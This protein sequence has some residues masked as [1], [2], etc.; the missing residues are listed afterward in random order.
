MVV[1]VMGVTGAGKTTVG[2]LLAEQCGWEFADAD[3]FH[4][5]S[6]VEKMRQ[7]IPLTDQD[8]QPWLE[9]LRGAITQ[10]IAD[11][12]NVVLACSSLKRAYR[13]EL[14]VAPE[15][16]FVFL[17]GSAGLIAER[18]RARHGHFAGEQILAGQFADLEEP[19][20]AVTVEIESTPPQIVAEIREK[21]GLA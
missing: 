16:H 21:L 14:D 3:E 5:A 11:G 15:V 13:Q 10:W 4:P 19:K 20:D 1:I 9:R 6:N 17:K 12:R 18:L 7:G 2:R 8:R